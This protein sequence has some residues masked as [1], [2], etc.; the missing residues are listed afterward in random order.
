MPLAAE[1]RAATTVV[2][3]GGQWAMGDGRW[4]MG[5]GRCGLPPRFGRAFAVFPL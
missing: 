5:D 3:G 2:G 4:A 1:M